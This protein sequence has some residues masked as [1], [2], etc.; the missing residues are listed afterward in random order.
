MEAKEKT[1]LFPNYMKNKLDS[2]VKT[3]KIDVFVN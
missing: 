2:F 3:P 1:V